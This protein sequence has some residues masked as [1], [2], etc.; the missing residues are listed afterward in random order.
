MDR[1]RIKVDFNEMVS[2]NLVLLSKSDS[3][4]DS[5]GN[6]IE[7]QEGKELHIY[8][9]NKYDDGEEEYLLACGVAELNDPEKNGSWTKAAKWCCRINSEG[10]RNVSNQ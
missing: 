4:K 10:I 3:V 2:E 6:L 5:E 7:L 8:E 9:F 1:A